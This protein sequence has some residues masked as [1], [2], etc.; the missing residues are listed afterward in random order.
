MEAEVLAPED[1][2]GGRGR[3]E[4]AL[5][6]AAQLGMRPEVAHCHLSLGKQYQRTGKRQEASEHLTTAVTMY[7]E[8]DMNFWLAQAEAAL[9]SLG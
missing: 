7:R 3:L 1:P 9:G 8:M 4:E 6:L 5:A 2:V